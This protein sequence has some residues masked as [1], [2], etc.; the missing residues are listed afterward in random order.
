MRHHTENYSRNHFPTILETTDSYF[1]S[2]ELFERLNLEY[3]HFPGIDFYTPTYQQLLSTY[4]TAQPNTDI[5]ASMRYQFLAHREYKKIKAVRESSRL[6]AKKPYRLGAGSSEVVLE[7]ALREEV[8][9]TIEEEERNKFMHKFYK[10]LMDDQVLHS[11]DQNV[12]LYKIINLMESFSKEKNKFG[13][14]AVMHTQTHYYDDPLISV[15]S[16]SISPPS[17]S[18]NPDCS[19]TS[20][21][22][23]TSRWTLL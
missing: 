15:S 1:W 10:G 2:H 4:Q 9:K 13:L 3:H 6:L 22:L 23:V 17:L 14:W 16:F 12:F 21:T 18:P 20:A 5:Y 11:P 7:D 19:T 8:S